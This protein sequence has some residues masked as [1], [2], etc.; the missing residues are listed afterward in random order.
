MK[1]TRLP[2]WAALLIG[3]SVPALAFSAAT[4]PTAAQLAT[5]VDNAGAPSQA[6][7]EPPDCKVNPKDPRCKGKN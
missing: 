4:S 2:I 1:N 6:P 7:S 5:G 3:L